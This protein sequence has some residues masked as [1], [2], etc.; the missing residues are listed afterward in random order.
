MLDTIIIKVMHKREKILI[1][2]GGFGGTKATLEL[3]NDDHFSVT[4]ISNDPDFRYYPTLYRTATGGSRANSSIPLKELFKETKV[5]LIN[6]EAETL[7]RAKKTITTK[8]GKSYEYDSLILSLGVITNYF[9]IPGLDEYSYGIKSQTE[10][11]RFKNHLHQQLIDQKKPDLN[12]VIVGAGPT[13]IELAGAL[14][15]YL[16]RILKNHG[17][18]PKKINIELIEA[19]PRLLPTMPRSVSRRVGKQLKKL[20]IKLYLGSKVEGETADALLVN[21][22]P[23]KSHSVIWTAGVTN[24]PFFTANHFVIMGHGKVAVDSYLQSEP[25]IYVLGDNANTPFSGL[26]QTALYDGGFVAN[27]LKLRAKGKTLKMY[28]ASKPITVIPAGNNWAIVL[29]GKLKFSGLLGYLIRE[30][31]DVRGF[32]ELES[33]PDTAKQFLS[34]FVSQDD[35]QV[36]ALAISKY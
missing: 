21:G 14:P 36:C 4:L 10:A 20:G 18:K 34:E 24:H 17:L 26:A 30:A 3:A 16:N 8:D 11:T 6:G 7:D 12:Y 9:N 31:A 5:E 35:C 27:N 25:N 1:I 23:I 29:W 15:S 13:G 2:G 28:N 22:V 33:W 19:M 32:H